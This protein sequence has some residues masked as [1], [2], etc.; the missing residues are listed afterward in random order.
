MI[1]SN[2]DFCLFSIDGN[3]KWFGVI[4]LQID[5][6]FI[7]ANNIFAAA[8]EKKLKKAKFLAKNKEKLTFDILIKFNIGYIKQA[9]NNSLFFSKKQQC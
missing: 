1:E 4:G 6:I 7:L 3:A 5:N 2:H 9:D 8:K